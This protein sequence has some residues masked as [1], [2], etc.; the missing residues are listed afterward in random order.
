MPITKETLKN[1]LER[2]KK[3]VP[4]TVK[5]RNVKDKVELQ[6]LEED[7]KP[8]WAKRVEVAKNFIENF[9]EYTKDIKIDSFKD[10]KI[11]QAQTLNDL[12]S[13]TPKI[14]TVQ[15]DG[16]T[17][18]ASLPNPPPL[19]IIAGNSSH[20]GGSAYRTGGN[21]AGDAQEEKYAETM[22]I[23]LAIASKVGE[24]I[25]TKGDINYN[26]Q[27]QEV[28]R[29]R[30]AL[31]VTGIKY[32][33]QKNTKSCDAIVSVAPDLNNDPKYA[34]L[35]LDNATTKFD[36]PRW[37][38]FINEIYK[39][40][41]NLAAAIDASPASQAVVLTSLGGG[42][43]SKESPHA[44]LIQGM[45]LRMAF[46]KYP[47]LKEKAKQGLLSLP[48]PDETIMKG[49]A[50]DTTDDLVEPIF[51]RVNQNID[52]S[53]T[54]K[55]IDE[56]TSKIKLYFID[57]LSSADENVKQQI[58]DLEFGYHNLSDAEYKDLPG[59]SGSNTS[60]IDKYVY[61]NAYNYFLEQIFK[62]LKGSK[63]SPE[64]KD[65][66]SYYFGHAKYQMGK[67]E[68]LSDFWGKFCKSFSLGAWDLS[69][70]DK[71]KQ[72]GDLLSKP[73]QSQQPQSPKQ[74]Q[75]TSTSKPNKPNLTPDEISKPIPTYTPKLSDAKEQ[76][77][78]QS[79]QTVLSGS[80]TVKEVN[81]Y[82]QKLSPTDQQN[83]YGISS[84]EYKEKN[85]NGKPELILEMQKKVQVYVKEQ[86]KGEVE[87]SLDK[88]FLNQTSEDSNA[89]SDYINQ[90][91]KLAVDTAKPGANFDTS[92]CSDAMRGQV[93]DALARVINEVNK[94]EEFKNNPIRL[95]GE[96][97]AT[98]RP[99]NS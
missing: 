49:F 31:K 21:G 90:I 98:V 39:M 88:K 14:K 91:C 44:K 11:S 86:V 20:I 17:Y 10:T 61:S 79:A 22:P 71:P 24:N 67:G 47:S 38:D 27:T 94:K 32:G 96:P 62:I 72:Q 35:V 60:T 64:Q 7:F 19:V 76:S 30:A 41:N 5:M 99:R 68:S 97:K 55:D 51:N 77:K 4:R 59:F 12:K 2:I 53:N 56:L 26:A 54:P 63:L 18:A 75:F 36:D 50:L 83:K 45:C 28:L 84:V 81:Q 74:T 92:L 69:P 87:Y 40:Y 15:I 42:V 8:R 82:L 43:Y 25:T 23:A 33:N 58:R 34:G 73:Q 52:R 13:Q 93:K 95:D 29:A 1:N 16:G 70:W 89:L 66:M 65:C 37:D 3:T 46:E 9:E 78:I 48:F 57:R 6:K 85:Q 80:N